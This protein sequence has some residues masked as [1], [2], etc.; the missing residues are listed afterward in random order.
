MVRNADVRV[1]PRGEARLAKAKADEFAKTSA[2]EVIAG[3]WSSAGLAA[4]HAGISAADAALISVAGVRGVAQDHHA[5]VTVLESRVPAFGTAQ[6]RHLAGLLKMKNTVEYERRGLTETEARQLVDHARR[7][8]DWADG[9]VDD[10][11]A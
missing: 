9:V 10:S 5:I 4:I 3:R 7:F 2:S 6:R 11:G 1:V 8:V